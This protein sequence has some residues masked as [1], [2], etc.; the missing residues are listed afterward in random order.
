[1]SPARGVILVPRRR[2]HGYRD[3]VWAW[4]RG[5]WE[6]E[7]PELPIFEGH[8]DSGLFNRSAACN[9]AA[10]AATEAGPWDVALLIDSDVI[11][12]PARVREAIAQAGSERNRLVL[13]FSRR[14]NLNPVGTARIMDGDQGSWVR[15]VAKTYTQMCSSCL[16]IPRQLWDEVGGFDERFEGWGFEDNAFASACSTFGADMTKIEG[17]LWHLWHPTA[18]EGRVGSPSFRANRTRADAYQAAI[19]NPAAI[20]ALQAGEEVTSIPARPNENIP[21]IL[22]RTIPVET[23]PEAEA[24][25]AAFGEMHPDWTLMTHQD[26]LNSA[27]WPLTAR[28]WPKCRNGAQLAGLIRLE[29][30]YRWGGIYVDQDV[31]PLRS[32]EP[33]L[34]LHAFAAWEDPRC[35]PDAVL[36]AEP[37]H[38]AIKR[39]LDLA[40]RRLGKGTWDSG[41]GVT[42]EVLRDRSDVLVF[43]PGT[44]YAVHYRDPERDAKMTGFDPA[45]APWAFALH[46]YWG[47]WLPKSAERSA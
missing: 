43:P 11:C 38:P 1:M 17:E 46:H 34:A 16:A 6:R 24:W 33:L 21:R 13:P 14:H 9:A 31:Q 45:T 26:P 36:G 3:Q 35:I 20:R 40:I 19:G 23:R 30:L 15:Y 18:P 4:V 8:H 29:A 5:W 44:F 2:D 28:H 10:A 37:E 7:L 41:P 32:L 39:C 22:H 12:D 42:T 25:W 27:A 47:S